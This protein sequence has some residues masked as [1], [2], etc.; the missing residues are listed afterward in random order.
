M[1]ELT[2]K[3][4]LTC[5]ESRKKCSTDTLKV[6]PVSNMCWYQ[7][8]TRMVTFNNLFSQIIISVYMTMY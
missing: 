8:P 3:P 7:T 5:G 4:D 6:F 1:P 2:P